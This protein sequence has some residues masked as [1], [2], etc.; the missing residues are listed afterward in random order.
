[1]PRPKPHYRLALSNLASRDQLRIELFDLPFA[2]GRSFRLRVNGKWACRIP[3]G[4][5][6]GSCSN[7]AVGG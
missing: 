5:R 3:A 1:M 4:A 2:T 7:C 6:P